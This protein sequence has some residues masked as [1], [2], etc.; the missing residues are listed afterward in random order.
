M[1]NK[2]II[3]FGFCDIQKN[4]GVVKGFQLRSA[5]VYCLYLRLRLINLTCTSTLIIQDITET[6][7]NNCYNNLLLTEREGRTEVVTV[8]TEQSEVRGK[9]TEGQYSPVRVEQAWL[10]SSQNAPSLIYRIL[11]SSEIIER[12]FNISNHSSMPTATY[13]TGAQSKYL[14]KS[15]TLFPRPYPSSKSQLP[16]WSDRWCW[17]HQALP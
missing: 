8:R 4:Q 3:R 13:Q 9:K 7:F 17:F 5:V 11:Q 14:D 15:T 6:S 10:V 16:C 12:N 2:T 1:C